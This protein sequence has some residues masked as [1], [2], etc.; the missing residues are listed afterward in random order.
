[1]GEWL[2]GLG[3]DAIDGTAKIR[4]V[5]EWLEAL[6]GFAPTRYDLNAM[7]HWRAWDLDRAVVDA[8]TQRT[9]LFRVEGTGVFMLALGKHG[10]PPTVALQWNGEADLGAW[11]KAI[12]TLERIT[13]GESVWERV[14]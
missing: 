14:R 3:G 7:E 5:L 10:E 2:L 1:M 9:Q 6:P 11:F 4:P 12:P 8:L 13:Q